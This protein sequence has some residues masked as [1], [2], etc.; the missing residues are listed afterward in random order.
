MSARCDVCHRK[1]M[2]GHN[3]SHSNRKTNRR[4]NL[5]LQSRRLLIDG[6]MKRVKI[7]T[8]CLR[9]MVKVPKVRKINR[10]AQAR[11]T[12]LATQATQAA[13]AAQVAQP[14]PVSAE[15]PAE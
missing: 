9:T 12:A 15:A 13:Q 6:E 5:N 10:A 2:Y 3:V 1:P 8:R 14:T 7:C 11:M 4:F